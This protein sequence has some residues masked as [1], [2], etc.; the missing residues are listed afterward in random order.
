MEQFLIAQGLPGVVILGLGTAV[1]ALWR[2]VSALQAARV[3][4]A[5]EVAREAAETISDNTQSAKAMTDAIRAMLQSGGR[6]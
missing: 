4:D 5:K 6:A 1:V 3:N 2:Q